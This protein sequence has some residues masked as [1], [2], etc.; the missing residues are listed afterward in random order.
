[1]SDASVHDSQKFEDILDTRNPASDGWAGSGDRSR[2]IEE[3]P[4]RRGLK[5]RIHRRAY[6]NRKLSEAQKAAHTTRSKVRA[7]AAHVFG[8]QKNAMGAG[9]VRTIGIVRARCKIGMT[10]LVSNIRR[11]LILERM[12][13]VARGTGAQRCTGAYRREWVD[14]IV[15]DCAGGGF[16]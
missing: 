2:E 10:N 15:S 1:V 11:F 3:K 5:S 4:G 8:D 14:Q 6:R 7:R 9:I 12:A 16:K 13:E